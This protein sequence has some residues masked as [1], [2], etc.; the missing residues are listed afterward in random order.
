VNSEG[1]T[2]I[3]NAHD[4]IARDK[5]GSGR[6]ATTK[7]DEVKHFSEEGS[8]G[9][10]TAKKVGVKHFSDEGSEGKANTKYNGA[11]HNS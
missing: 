3:K 5:E 2:K 8:G 10:A 11:N 1:Q 7:D 6:K 4:M 9:N